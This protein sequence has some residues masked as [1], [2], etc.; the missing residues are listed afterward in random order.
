MAYRLSAPRIAPYFSIGVIAAV[1]VWYALVEPQETKNVPA[2]PIPS[3]R[4]GLTAIASPSSASIPGLPASIAGSNAPRL[5]IDAAGHLVRS[6]RVRDFFDYFLI[7]QHD[8][9]SSVLDILVAHEIAAQ[10]DGTIARAEALDV[11]R[12]YRAYFTALA[13]QEGIDEMPGN[14]F[15]PAALQLALDR[16]ATLA[17]RTLGEWSVPFF[18]REQE[19][20]RFDLEKL[21]IAQDP[22]LNDEQ[23]RERLAQLDRQLPADTQARQADL[24]QK[25]DMVAQLAQLAKVSASP[26]ET[27]AQ[28]AQLLGPEAGERAAQLQSADEAWQSKYR[29]YAS[30][31]AQ[32]DSQG[33]ATQDRDAQVEK[34]RARFFSDAGD[35]LRAASYDRAVENQHRND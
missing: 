24:T 1:V 20:Q 11:W 35:S 16:R 17:S 4:T 22:L 34:L 8:V 10:L 6:R 3:T 14:K 32:I 18:G 12:R 15:D 19:R 9:T 13:Q 30:Q 31:R 21:K 27:R 33:L 5:P 7:A 28:V 25:Q 29:D 26:D 2:T 23:R